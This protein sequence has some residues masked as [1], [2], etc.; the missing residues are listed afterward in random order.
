[1]ICDSIFRQPAQLLPLP[2]MNI[3]ILAPSAF[4][5]RD[6]IQSQFYFQ[7]L[8]ELLHSQPQHHFLIIT[9]K[10]MTSSGRFPGDVD[11]I[12]SPA[13]SRPTFFTGIW[14]SV[15]LST[16]LKKKNA[17]L[18]LSLD[19]NCMKNLKVPQCVL[20]TD[21]Q[22]LNRSC[23]SKARALA[24][25]TAKSKKDI[26]D[27]YSVA[28]KKIEVIYAAAGDIFHPLNE[29][30]KVEVKK[31]FTEGYDY[32]LYN[33]P[34]LSQEDFIILLKAFSLF[35]KRQKSY[36]RLVLLSSINRHY[37]KSLMNYKYSKDV[38]IVGRENIMEVAAL[39]AAA[40]AC[41]LT[42]EHELNLIPAL[43][44]MQS[45]VP[46]VAVAGSAIS[47]T[48]GDAVYFATKKDSKE[49]GECMMR[50][51]TD[52]QFRKQFIEKGATIATAY[53]WRR[54]TDLLWQAMQNALN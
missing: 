46:V 3:A 31:K 38:K 11:Y 34:Q 35:K 41:I 5:P 17:D 36:I 19:G 25:I 10:M 7:V 54:T 20:V 50:I 6:N 44:A 9:D 42:T 45:A 12:L 26:T 30:E 1:M 43:E 48:F 22:K 40:Y 37:E 13:L 52:E 49:I 51:Y 16:I 23:I 28:D 21:V 32:F 53:S 14:R 24:V 15:Y 4:Q 8:T 27:R 2:E 39:S 47:S 29:E 33:G 18:I